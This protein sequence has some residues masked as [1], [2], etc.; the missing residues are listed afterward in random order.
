MNLA[1]I[2]ILLVEDDPDDLD[3]ALMAINSHNLANQIHI[4]RDGAEA[5]DIIFCTGEHAR[6][7]FEDSMVVVLL[8]LNLPKIDGIEVLRR[9]RSDSQTK[10]IP[11][12]MMTASDEERDIVASYRY[13][14][15][16]Y[17]VKPLDFM[18]FSETVSRLG[19]CWL[20]QRREVEI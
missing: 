10:T 19:F 2:D 20:L 4:A 14:A 3:L 7:R 13:G 5:L 12:I 17:I 18:K 1:A 8:D 16:S 9:I 11:V 15:N 6:R